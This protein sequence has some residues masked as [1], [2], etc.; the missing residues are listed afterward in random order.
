MIELE[1]T[2]KVVSHL[3]A[4]SSTCFNHLMCW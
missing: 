3:S 2:Q 4:N 1:F